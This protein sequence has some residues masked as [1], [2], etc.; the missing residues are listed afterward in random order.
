MEVTSPGT[1][2]IWDGALDTRPSDVGSVSSLQWIDNTICG[3]ASVLNLDRPPASERACVSIRR[4]SMTMLNS[5][6]GISQAICSTKFG[7]TL[8]IRK[9]W[10]QH[11]WCY[12]QYKMV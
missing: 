4:W 6:S 11:L 10:N 7:C 1:D 2:S 9:Q 8:H 3:I 12:K 5:G